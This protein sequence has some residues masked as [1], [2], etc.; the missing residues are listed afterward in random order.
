MAKPAKKK[1]TK[2]AA[3]KSS[4]AAAKTKKSAK[5]SAKTAKRKVA[6]KPK[7]KAKV[8]KKSAKTAKSVKKPVA[9]KRVATVRRKKPAVKSPA[10]VAPMIAPA[11]QPA[12]ETSS[13]W[14][15]SGSVENVVHD[16]FDQAD[17]GSDEEANSAAA[18]DSEY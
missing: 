4:K 9:K 6:S 11:A 3:K 13:P 16:E 7:A 5:M 10:E 8:A 17:L 1:K 18:G 2:S 12:S 14:G 15:T